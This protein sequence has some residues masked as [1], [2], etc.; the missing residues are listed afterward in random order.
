MQIEGVLHHVGY[1]RAPPQDGRVDPDR[2]VVEPPAVERVRHVEAVRDEH[3]VGRADLFSVQE[4]GCERVDA[5]EH[6]L[7]ALIVL[8]AGRVE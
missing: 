3:V 7:G 5:V 1:P 4:D 2:D 8:E 6:E